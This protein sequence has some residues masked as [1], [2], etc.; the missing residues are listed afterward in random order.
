MSLPFKV[1]FFWGEFLACT[2]PNNEPYVSMI[3]QAVSD[4]VIDQALKDILIFQQHFSVQRGDASEVWCRMHPLP[5]GTSFHLPP[6]LTIIKPSLTFVVSSSSTMKDQHASTSS[7]EGGKK[8]NADP[9]KGQLTAYR[10]VKSAYKDC[11]PSNPSTCGTGRR[12]NFTT[13]STNGSRFRLESRSGGGFHA[14]SSPS[15]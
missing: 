9:A 6:L 5:P 14:I 7:N 3:R 2:D 13:Y 1:N 11:I 15:I 4:A 12:V 8:T 10:V